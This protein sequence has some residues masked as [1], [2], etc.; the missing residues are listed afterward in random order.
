MLRK[1]LVL[2]CAA[3][4]CAS[5]L[6]DSTSDETYYFIDAADTEGIE[7]FLTTHKVIEGE[8]GPELELTDPSDPNNMWNT[9]RTQAL[10]ENTPYEDLI[11]RAFEDTT[12]V[13]MITQAGDTVPVPAGVWVYIN[14][15]GYSTNRPTD[16]SAVLVTYTGTLLNEQQ[17]T[18]APIG[19]T[20]YLY[21]DNIVGFR[22][23][24]KYLEPG[25]LVTETVTPEPDEDGTEYPPYDQD[26]WKDGGQGWI[27]IPSKVGYGNLLASD[28]PPNSVLIFNIDLLSVAYYPTVESGNAGQT[29]SLG[30]KTTAWINTPPAGKTVKQSVK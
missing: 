22:L 21:S 30:H 16:S 17:F 20:I 13:K 27:I 12:Q 6:K 4:V 28:V 26:V 15:R 1:T 7:L 29:V 23:G 9:R 14:K 10:T 8:Y 5:C 11:G 3:L 19:S 24:V 2:F 18:I 25:H